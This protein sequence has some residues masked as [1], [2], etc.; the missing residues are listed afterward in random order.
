MNINQY[1]ETLNKRYITGIASEHTYR[2][3]LESLIRG[4]VNDIE[5]TNEP[6]QVTDCGNPDYVITR[7]NIPIG[8]IEAKDIG[9]D[10]GSKL[11]E[12]QF[13]RYQNALD[14]LIITDYIY[15]Q[16]FENGKQV[17]DIRLANIE[18]NVIV[19]NVDQF[20][21]FTNLIINF[22]SRNTQAIKSPIKLAE[23]MAG[24]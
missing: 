8:Y 23:L 15:F 16:F 4:L 6:S 3:D 13:T 7:K 12:E 21:K 19:P 9:K 24:K 20:E 14:N 10:L 17:A 22:S 11:Y 2:A 5:V 1:L 18:N